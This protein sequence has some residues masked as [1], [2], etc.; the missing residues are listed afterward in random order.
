MSCCVQPIQTT[1]APTAGRVYALAVL[2]RTCEYGPV[3]CEE[4]GRPCGEHVLSG[5]CPRGRHAL[6]GTSRWWYGV[7]YPLRVLA[8]VLGGKAAKVAIVPGCGC[9]RPAK[10]AWERF[11]ANRRTA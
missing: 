3:T 7:P 2:C 1:T 4:S 8:R 10:D 9:F 6:V 5:V 11:K